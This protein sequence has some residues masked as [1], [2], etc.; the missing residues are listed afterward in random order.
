MKKLLPIFIALFFI[1][2]LAY[3]LGSLLAGAFMVK[4]EFSLRYFYLIFDNPFYS[5]CFVNS[6]LI[7]I[8]STLLALAISLPL[9]WLFN[10]C[11]FPAKTLLNSLLLL[12]LILPPFVGAIGLRQFF[13]RYG[14]LNLV[15]EKIG[16][17][18]LA[19]PPDWLASG[20]FYGIILLQALH[21]YPILF[22]SV[23]AAMANLD[24]AL[25]EAAA[26]LGARG[27]RI[28]RTVTLPLALPGIFSGTT[29]VFIAAFTDLGVPLMFGFQSTVPS[30]IFNMV[31]QPDNPMGYALVVLTLLLVSVLFLLGKRIGSGNYAMTMRSGSQALTVKLGKIPA[32]TASVSVLLLIAIS[33]IPHIG[34]V[35]QSISARWFMTALPSEW[36]GQFYREV[37]NLDATTLSVKNS[38]FYSICSMS[39]DLLLGLA[40]AWLLTREKFRGKALLDTVS[41]LPLALPGLVLAF[42]YY[43]TFSRHG[44]WLA[45]L[46]PRENPVFLL[47]IAYSMHRLP[48]IVRAAYAGFQ[49]VSASLEE[50]STNLGAHPLRTFC[51]ISLPLIA[52]NLVAGSILTFS[53]AMLDVSNSLIL[54][55]EDR[56]YP[57]TKAIYSLM[58]R[59]TP[60]APNVACA[61]G[62]LALLLLALSLYLASKLMGQ[63]MGQLFKS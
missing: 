46:D 11:T 38:L 31:V 59:I 55:Q 33:V 19:N 41:M 18:N 37:F 13:T 15:L 1:V 5:Q 27:W 47:V 21:L 20:G 50:A 8:W 45:F 49:Q 2:F 12:P 39:L 40:I 56:F 22:L 53:F 51:K 54:A 10:R 32:L 35:L 52:A 16:L 63:K 9:A 62:V 42:A 30:Q 7:A 4:G 29:I 14:T 60:T 3:P 58:G 34:V 26:N 17:V 25:R 44:S 23:Q 36:S 6:T 24:P 28:F 48:Y 57:I 43:V 61:L